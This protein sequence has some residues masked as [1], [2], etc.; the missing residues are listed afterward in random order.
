[1]FKID[2]KRSLNDIYL[3]LKLKKTFADGISVEVIKITAERTYNP[4]KEFFNPYL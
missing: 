4:V 1:M 3:D 2:E